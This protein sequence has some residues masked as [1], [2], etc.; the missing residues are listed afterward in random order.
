MLVLPVLEAFQNSW[1]ILT[2]HTEEELLNLVEM[3]IKGLEVLKS[4]LGFEAIGFKK[5]GGYELFFQNQQDLY[6]TCLD[7]V[8]YINGLLKPL[9]NEAV[10]SIKSNTQNFRNIQPKL[11]FNKEEGELD[12][13]KMIKALVDLAQ[14]KNIQILNTCSVED[15]QDLG[16]S[17]TLKTSLAEFKTRKLFIVTNGFAQQLG[18]SRV[19]PARNQVLITKPIK[20]LHLKGTY[21]LD[22]GYTYFR[23]IDNRIL[24]GGGRNLDFTGEQTDSFGTTTQIQSYLEHVLTEVVLPNTKTQIEHRWSGILGVGDQKQP[25]IRPLSENVFCG[26]RLGG[27]GIAIG[28]LLG[29]ELAAFGTG[30]NL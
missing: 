19:Q 18:V 8:N 24:L 4:R 16:D 9:F 29:K 21:H 11:L 7:S 13:G 3:R 12:T 26:V 1:P 28:S 15:Y 5:H 2:I 10:F 23:A 22:E 30:S 14:L 20:N 25:I 17:V 6:E 27:M